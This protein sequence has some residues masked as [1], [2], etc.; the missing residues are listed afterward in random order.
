[1]LFLLTVEFYALHQ[2]QERVIIIT[3]IYI[4]TYRYNRDTGTAEA[5]LYSMF[6]FPDSNKT[7]LTFEK[8][9]IQHTAKKLKLDKYEY[10]EPLNKDIKLEEICQQ[11]TDSIHQDVLSTTNIFRSRG[12]VD[13]NGTLNKLYLRSN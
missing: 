2:K 9:N 6:K 1:V 4:Y 10:I 12:Y 8:Y 11:E 7:N 13:Q 5:T 3:Y